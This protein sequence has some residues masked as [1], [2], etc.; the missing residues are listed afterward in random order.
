[1]E[2]FRIGHQ[3]LVVSHR[4]LFSDLC[5][6][7]MI[8]AIDVGLNNF[9]AKFADDMKLGKSVISGRDRQSLQDDLSK[10]SAWSARWEMPFNV[11]K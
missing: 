1:M 4:A 8:N 6:S 5:H 2:L 11:M 3:S 7:C 9:T 10:I